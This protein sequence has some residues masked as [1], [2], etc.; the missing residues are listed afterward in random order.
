MSWCLAIQC[1]G[2]WSTEICNQSQWA[3][4]TVQTSW[5]LRWKAVEPCKTRTGIVDLL[6]TLIFFFWCCFWIMAQFQSSYTKQE[7]FH[8]KSFGIFS[9]FSRSWWKTLPETRAA[10][11]P[12]ASYIQRFPCDF[13]ATP[14][15]IP[16]LKAWVTCFGLQEGMWG[17][18]WW[19]VQ[20]SFCDVSFAIIF[21]SIG[22]LFVHQLFHDIWIK[23]GWA[24]TIGLIEGCRRASISNCDHIVFLFRA[25]QIHTLETR[26][27][28][29]LEDMTKIC[30][31]FCASASNIIYSCIVSI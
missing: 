6:D 25:L 5:F 31:T 12:Q 29:L 1:Q 21:F 4:Q 18:V 13:S 11:Q 10:P 17:W 22:D 15:T 23:R 16:G 8:I 14:E 9:F 27:I 19:R 7:D 3:A 28:A 2:P 24:L 26:Q 30:K 20:N